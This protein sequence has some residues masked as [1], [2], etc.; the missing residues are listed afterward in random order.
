MG[1]GDEDNKDF[2]AWV[3]PYDYAHGDEKG[4]TVSAPVYDRSVNPPMFV[5]VVGIDFTVKFMEEI[6]GS[7]EL[8][9]DIAL[10]PEKAV[11][12]TLVKKSTARCPKLNLND[13]EL[14][15][16]RKLSGG[17]AAMCPG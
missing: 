8:A 15:A 2:V 6:A 13:C 10:K 3:E 17:D 9:Y 11:L 12:N 7:G 5:G 16:M 14:Q 1:L 4:T